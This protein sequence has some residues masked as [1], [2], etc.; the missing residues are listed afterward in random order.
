M[1]SLFDWLRDPS[2]KILD[3]DGEGRL[4]AHSSVLRR[5]RL[6]REV[7]SEF[8]HLFHSLDEQFLSAK[9][10]RIEIGAGVAP[11]RESYADV[12]ATD[13]VSGPG[14]D[15]T[16]NAEDMDLESGS[17]RVV[18][19]Q[20]CFHH[21]PHPDRFFQQLEKVL[22]PGGGAILLEP[23][24]GPF[25]TFLFK[26]LFRTE[27]Y[28]K[29][30]QSWETPLIGPMNGANQALSY[31]VFIRDRQS[32]ECK[33][34]TLKIVHQQTCPNYLKYMLSGGLN[35]RQMCP[36]WASPIISILQWMLS[37]LNR[38]LALHH[39]VVLKKVVV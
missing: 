23:Y 2:V 29:K 14:L 13:I 12:L 33:F 6:L 35:F 34:P 21:F 24:Y 11:I 8:H 19:G 7:F 30:F 38:W 25:A 16:L 9:G 17:V 3:V 31:I 32:F 22:P 28:D 27:G 10:L 20:N 5:K 26:R 36:N 1:K 37:P 15:R 39:V 18:F 4:I